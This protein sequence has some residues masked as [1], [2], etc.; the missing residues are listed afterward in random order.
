MNRRYFLK[1]LT[2]LPFIPLLKITETAKDK[3]L[4]K[5]LTL[6]GWIRFDPFEFTEINTTTFSEKPVKK[7]R[8][9]EFN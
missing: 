1:L 8:Y 5:P 7:Y 6:S 4:T 3:P 9:D 2:A